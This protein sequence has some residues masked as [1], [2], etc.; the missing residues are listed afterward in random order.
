MEQNVERQEY[1]EYKRKSH[2]IVILCPFHAISQIKSNVV[3]ILKITKEKEHINC[4]VPWT[5]PVALHGM[6]N[7][8]VPPSS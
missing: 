4:E 5:E 3:R 8:L 6:D 2:N 1:I 7:N